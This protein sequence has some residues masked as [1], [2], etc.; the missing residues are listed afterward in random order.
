MGIE[1]S[2]QK[3]NQLIGRK[4]LTILID[5]KGATP[6]REDLKAQIAAKLMVKPD[7]IVIQE[8]NSAY[9]GSRAICKA[10]VYKDE[11]A[12]KKYTYDYL[13]ARGKPKPKKE[14]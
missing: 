7:L 13:T 4:E 11:A 5:T 9:G 14:G 6:K 2:E 3:D 8:L 1:I 10:Y 12:M